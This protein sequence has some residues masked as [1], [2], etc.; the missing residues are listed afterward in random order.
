MMRNGSPASRSVRH[1]HP[2]R[3]VPS[4]VVLDDVVHPHA[5]RA[6]VAEPRFDL[7]GEIVEASRRSR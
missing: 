2:R 5:E 1:L 3:A 7:V 4:G 6:A